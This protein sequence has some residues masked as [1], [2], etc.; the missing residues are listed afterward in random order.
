MGRKASFIAT[1]LLCPVLSPLPSLYPM[2]A[3]DSEIKLL[4]NQAGYDLSCP[5]RILLQTNFDPAL[6]LDYE[7]I[8][9]NNTVYRGKWERPLKIDL[10]GLWYRATHLP[11]SI[12]GE[13]RVRV[14]WEGRVIESPA[15]IVSA[16][17]LFEHTAP[18][19]AY[20]FYAQRC[21]VE[22]PGWH[23][24]CHLDDAVLADGSHRDLSGG[25]HDAGDYNKYNGYTPLAVYALSQLAQSQALHT[26]RWDKDFP[27]PQEEALWG[28]RW[29]VKCRDEKTGKI[30]GRV[31]SGFGFWGP[32]EA[33]TDNAVGNDDDRKVDILEWNENEMTVAAWAS[34]YR[35]TG[36]DD[37][38]RLALNLWQVVSA[39]DPGFSPVARAKR[40]LAATELSLST[41]DLSFFEEGQREAIF[42]LSQQER[43]G[44]WPL[45]PLAIVDYGLPSAALARFVLAFP[46]SAVSSS[47]RAALLRSIENWSS[48]MAQ[49]FF[50]PRW[51]AEEVFYPYLPGGWYVGQNSMYLSQAWAG[52]LMGKV[53]P[54][55]APRLK[56]WV[57][58]CLDWLLGVNPFGICM[59]E[60]AGSVHLKM[61]HHRYDQI[62]NGKNGRVPGAIPNG[63]TRQRADV[64]RPYL[65]LEGK[66]WPTNEPW[67]PHNAYYLLVLSERESRGRSQPISSFS[68]RR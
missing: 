1:L 26:A 3:R 22:V 41:G 19:A 6:I 32:P 15:F 46:E 55:Q 63:I 39:H 68:A 59:M 66:S 11:I 40:L 14:L 67:L 38:K 2:D 17:R 52:L 37:W 21:G 50:I 48:K 34:V 54:R 62:A 8:K 65:D 30:I 31:F 56:R 24:A 5:K 29:L 51:S 43:G 25:W 20:F 12:P 27:S 7:I 47:I 4:V 64:D 9:N 18:L 23:A 61:Y 16:N 13:Y 28:A 35:M 42:L 45:W 33:E 49:P 36:D 60:G 44:G 10:W 58:G 53:L 57:A